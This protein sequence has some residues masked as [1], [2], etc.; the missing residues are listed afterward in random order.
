MNGN[1]LY[2]IE[3]EQVSLDMF[4]WTYSDIFE[5]LMNRNNS[6]HIQPEQV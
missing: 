5:N 4:I 6:Y 2:H 3:S 1:N